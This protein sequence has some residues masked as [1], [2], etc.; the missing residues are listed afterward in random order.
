VDGREERGALVVSLLR[1]GDRFDIK[2]RKRSR[3]ND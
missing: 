3:P 2:K 1:P